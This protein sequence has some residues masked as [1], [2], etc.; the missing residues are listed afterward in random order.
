VKLREVKSEW[1][2]FRSHAIYDMKE[3]IASAIV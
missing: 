1:G 3:V 2:R